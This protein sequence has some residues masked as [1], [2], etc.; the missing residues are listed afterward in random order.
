MLRLRRLLVCAALIFGFTAPAVGASHLNAAKGDWFL[1]EITAGAGGAEEYQASYAGSG[2][3][4]GE[5]V[6]FGGALATSNG[7]GGGT[8]PGFGT[9]LIVGAKAG[10]VH[11]ENEVVPVEGGAFAF[12]ST[13][14]GSGLEPGEKVYSLNFFSGT[15]SRPSPVAVKAKAGSIEA[16]LVSGVGS[17]AVLL[18]DA[19]NGVAAEAVAAGAGLL[20][21]HEVDSPGLV[22]AFVECTLCTGT[23][24]A[25]DGRTGQNQSG[26]AAFSGPAGKWG[27]EWSG[28]VDPELGRATIGGYAPVGNYWR[29]FDFGPGLLP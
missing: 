22:G 10:P 15:S 8:F 2:E 29:H 25:P 4:T 11:M 19:G 17:K 9:S 7:A 1:L 20:T 13:V 16:E 14:F 27:L 23:W 26:P 18:F 28:V 5:P 6:V 12:T 21:T 3:M 24:N